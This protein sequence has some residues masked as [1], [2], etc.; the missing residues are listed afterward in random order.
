ML[1]FSSRQ[2]S[3][4]LKNLSVRTGECKDEPVAGETGGS[5]QNFTKAPTGALRS[6]IELFASSFPRSSS[7]G[8]ES[9]YVKHAIIRGDLEHA[10]LMLQK[11]EKIVPVRS[12]TL[13]IMYTMLVNAFAK[14]KQVNKMDTL[15]KHMQQTGIC[16]DS[17]TYLTFIHAFIESGNLQKAEDVFKVMGMSMHPSDSIFT[18]MINGY[19]VA[20]KIEQVELLYQQAKQCGLLSPSII[21]AMLDGYVSKNQFLKGCKMFEDVQQF[22]ANTNKTVFLSFFKCGIEAGQLDIATQA[23]GQLLGTDQANLSILETLI[24][25]YLK[26][27]FMYEAL[28]ILVKA[29]SVSLKPN[30]YIF[31]ILINYC[32]RNTDI[33]NAEM[34]FQTA[35]E[36]FHLKPQLFTFNSLI[37]GYAKISDREKA[38]R[39]FKESLPAASLQPDDTTLHAM[40]F[41]YSN[42]G[43]KEEAEHMFQRIERKTT[44]SYNTM[45]LTHFQNP[46]QAEKAEKL[47]GVMEE[48]NVPMD[49]RTYYLMLKGYVKSGEFQHAKL[50]ARSIIL[51]RIS[52]E[53]VHPKLAGMLRKVAAH[54]SISL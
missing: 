3:H 21:S 37:Y 32:V 15:F 42:L 38:E 7:R 18:T 11:L 51:P 28:Y 17:Q 14:Q 20:H 10:E 1:A 27:N 34:V 24:R 26:H 44:N 12:Q 33:I 4:V 49:H 31:N 5:K 19:F 43:I 35:T 39:L 30:M 48:Q 8:N 53:S 9:L 40:L 16:M 25:A 13:S 2:Y 46:P 54:P 6:S 45:L 23:F 29:S 36:K 47:L 52:K 41:L 50:F 22:R